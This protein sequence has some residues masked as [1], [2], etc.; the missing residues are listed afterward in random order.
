MAVGRSQ[1]SDT[2]DGQDAVR[3]DVWLWAAR[4]YKTRS[5]SQEAVEGGRVQV[6]GQ[7]SKPGRRVHQGDL[8]SVSKESCGVRT[9]VIKK[10]EKKR[11]G[12]PLAQCLYEE[13]EESRANRARDEEQRLRLGPPPS[14]SRP[15]KKERRA[16]MRL[17]RGPVLE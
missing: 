4:F 13:T 11:Q 5:L 6:N 9:L 17:R 10:L 16:L 12:A 8:V 2:E 15:N 14:H 1:S 7:R 3:I